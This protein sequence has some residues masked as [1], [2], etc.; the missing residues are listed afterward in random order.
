MIV[1][2]STKES[3]TADVE[4]GAVED[5]IEVQYEANLH[6][7]VSPNE[8]RSWQNSMMYMNMVLSDDEIPSDAGVTIELQIPQTSKRIDFIITGQDDAKTDH[9]VIVELKQWESAEVTVMDGI[10]RTFLGGGRREVSHPSYQAWTYS[11]LLS[12][13][14]EAVYENDIRLKACAYL[15]N[16]IPNGVLDNPF[17]K[18][19]TERA[20]VF[21]KTDI[22]KLRSFIKEF[23][24]YGDQS[25]IIYKIENGN[26]R[27]SKMLADKLSSMLKGNEEF[28]MIDEQKVAFEYVMDAVLHA[29]DKKK[30]IIIEGGP[31][32]GKSVVAINLL[33]QLTQKEKFVS[34]VTKNSAP[35]T[36]YSAMLK[37]DMKK[38]HIDNLFR[39]SGAFTDTEENTFD[40]LIIDEA[41]RL[42]DK[43]G[44]FRN[45][46]ENQIKELI[47]SSNVA[48]FFIDED[49]RIHIHDIGRKEE[50]RHWA[51]RAGADVIETELASQF[52]CNGSDGYLAWLDHTLQIQETANTSLEDINYDFRVCSSPNEVFNLIEEKNR[53]T[54]KSRIV[55]GYCWDWKSKKDPEAM[56]IVIEEF[57]FAKKWNLAIDGMLWMLKEESINEIGCIHTCQGLELEYVGVIIGPDFK[58]RAGEVITDIYERS[59]NDRSI[60][61]MKKMFREDPDRAAILAD[62]IVKNTY[63]TLMSRGMK[64]CYIYCTD[65]ETEEYFKSAVK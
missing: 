37:K 29:G 45:L 20:P 49:Q 7:R 56:D 65:R 57:D 16:Y 53:V 50:I 52:R 35:R 48:V 41:H 15:H 12:D 4:T 23:V 5:I 63:R 2:K 24:K 61:G 3:F 32:T 30:V 40:A 38:S 6:R 59:S 8:K 33:V 11:A 36:V 64:G 44:M 55:A 31:G 21:M 22:S 47:H 54:N 27:P 10:V 51:D 18:E 9:A 26:I 1:Y 28:V 25:D 34:Y 39:S 62:E 17:Y 13:F 58:I 60:F 14:N 19:H 42:N 46:G 43:S